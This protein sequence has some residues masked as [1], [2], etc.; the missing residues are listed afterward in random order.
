[1]NIIKLS[2]K[3]AAFIIIPLAACADTADIHKLNIG[4]KINVQLHEVTISGDTESSNLP[5]GNIV[6]GSVSS[7]K[8]YLSKI[9]FSVKNKEYKLESKY[10]YNAWGRRPLEI[11]GVIKYFDA[12]CYNSE[13]CT[14]RGIFSDA[15]GS[16]VAEWKV[17]NGK[18]IRTVITNSGD[19][20][21]NFIKD[22][23]PPVYE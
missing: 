22:I 17:I 2:I 10:M 18:A 1:M 8:T 14:I 21:N 4:N 12:H 16:F 13:N 23:S 15:A 3:I 7:P 19:I 20:V 5:N 9:I 11:A 6:F